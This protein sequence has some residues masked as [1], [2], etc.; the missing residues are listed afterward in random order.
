MT[1]VEEDMASCFFLTEI[2]VNV[3]TGPE[4]ED[5]RRPR[6]GQ[7]AG[8]DSSGPGALVPSWLF[9]SGRSKA[10][11]HSPP[12][13]LFRKENQLRFGWL[14]PFAAESIPNIH[15]V[16]SKILNF[17]KVGFEVFLCPGGLL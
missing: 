13:L 5:G 10:I 11:G 8:G 7:H 6:G 14:S 4:G 9:L 1:P 3:A 16:H 17:S 15:F 2:A 12:Y